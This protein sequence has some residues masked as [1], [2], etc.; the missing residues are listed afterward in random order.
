[1]EPMLR[2]L[3]G[4]GL[5]AGLMYFLDPQRGRHRRALVRDQFTHLAHEACAAA[6]VTARDAA[7]R[8]T[9]LWAEAKAVVTGRSADDRTLAERVRAHLGRCVSHPRAIAVAA[10][11]GT[12]TL[13]GP[14]L[15]NEVDGLLACVRAV[16]GVSGV[17]NRLEPHDRADNHPALRG[18]LPRTG[19]RGELFQ[20]RW[21]QTF[22]LLAGAAGTA[23]MANC[24]AK[25]DFG[26]ALLGT[27]GFGLFLRAATN[28]GLGEL[29]DEAM[30][31][32]SVEGSPELL[33]VAAAGPGL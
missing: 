9:G 28:T 12:I 5:G 22:R 7:N 25:R 33:T 14:I 24:L 10:E 2:V 8:A 20:A 3:G 18:G 27:L 32:L 31:T 23:L 15:A 17:D 29:I 13:S 19:A 30:P 11:N 26:A 21:S 4:I 1:M 6:D 16:P